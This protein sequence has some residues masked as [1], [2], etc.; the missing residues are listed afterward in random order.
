MWWKRFH[1]LNLP[2]IN[3]KIR[4]QFK[5]HSQEWR[6]QFQLALWVPCSTRDHT[7]LQHSH[8]Q[9]SSRSCNW[10]QGIPPGHYPR[11]GGCS[12]GN[13]RI[14][15]QLITRRGLACRCEGWQTST[16][17]YTSL[18]L[19]RAPDNFD[20]S[21]NRFCNILVHRQ[22][23]MAAYHMTHFVRKDRRQLLYSVHA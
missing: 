18:P 4:M 3:K 5:R 6:Q 11:F 8:P 7:G 13:V 10:I 19:H 9:L 16:L 1:I 20:T 21:E 12:K 15:M 14:P 17:L 23:K 22:N 2:N